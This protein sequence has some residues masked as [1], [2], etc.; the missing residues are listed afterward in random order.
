[1]TGQHKL[2]SIDGGGIRGVLAL[3]ILR[4]LETQLA[5]AQGVDIG[6]FRLSDYFD[7]V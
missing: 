6:D 2:L 5:E 4:R 1:M 3:E 7:Y